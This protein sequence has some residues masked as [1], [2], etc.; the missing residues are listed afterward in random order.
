MPAKE[1]F[2]PRVQPGG[3]LAA[4]FQ[5]SRRAEAFWHTGIATTLRQ[6][7]LCLDEAEGENAIFIRAHSSLQQHFKEE[8]T[9]SLQKRKG[10]FSSSERMKG[11][12]KIL[13]RRGGW[14]LF[15]CWVFLKLKI[16]SFKQLGLIGKRN[17]CLMSNA[18]V[19]I[20]AFPLWNW[21]EKMYLVG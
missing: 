1:A 18:N 17:C 10:N 19:K 13:L 6:D 2:L 5:R 15:S 4:G 21:S 20:F 12:I 11:R 8:I 3:R 16:F 9:T 14:T 7:I